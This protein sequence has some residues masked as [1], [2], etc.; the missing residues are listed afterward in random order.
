MSNIN[1]T[2]PAAKTFGARFGASFEEV[3]A[4][5]PA[6]KKEDAQFWLNIGY[7]TQATNP[8]TGEVETV[9][10]ALPYGVALDPMKDFDLTQVTN[11]NMA[12]LRR[13]QNHLL[14]QVKDAAATLEPGEE[15]LLSVDEN[16]GMA[17]QLRRVK[18]AAAV[19][20]DDDNALIK[21]LKLV[22]KA[23]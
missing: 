16:T 5:A 14:A 7:Q 20:A 17:V 9:F 11:A 18:S 10:V 15:M 21:P 23:A 8:Q 6:R 13:A 3:E 1:A 22:A 12:R 4:A 2:A 19:P